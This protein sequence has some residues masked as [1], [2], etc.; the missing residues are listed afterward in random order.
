MGTNK[1][2]YI[3]VGNNKKK[4]YGNNNFVRNETKERLW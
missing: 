1:S 3:D 4:K 2:K